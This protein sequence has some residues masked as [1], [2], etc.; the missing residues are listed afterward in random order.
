MA[1]RGEDNK[2]RSFIVRNDGWGVALAN[3]YRG[4]WGGDYHIK[5]SYK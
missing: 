3:Q 5:K 4:G 1:S 2:H